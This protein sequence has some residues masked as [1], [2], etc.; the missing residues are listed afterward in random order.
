MELVGPGA[1]IRTIR[2]VDGED[3]AGLPM[4]PRQPLAVTTAGGVTVTFDPD[5]ATTTRPDFPPEVVR[6]NELT[7][8]VQP[9]IKPALEAYRRGHGGA[10]P[11]E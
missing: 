6:L 8:R 10:M 7:A 2:S 5:G 9:A 11:P 4:H 3:Y 1:F